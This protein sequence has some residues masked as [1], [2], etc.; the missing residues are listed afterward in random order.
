MLKSVKGPTFNIIQRPDD[1]K[2]AKAKS[3]LTGAGGW[4]TI[5]VMFLGG[6]TLA[7]VAA[8]RF[9]AQRMEAAGQR[10]KIL[11]CTTGIVS[12]R[13]VMEGVIEKANLGSGIKS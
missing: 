12:G 13:S 3:S 8:L 5:V 11:I 2:A 6:I 9:V 4:K 7:E 10:R 1:E